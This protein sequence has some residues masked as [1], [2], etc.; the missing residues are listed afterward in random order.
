MLSFPFKAPKGQF[1]NKKNLAQSNCQIQ[2][3]LFDKQI[4][5]HQE[6]G[7]I[8]L[9]EENRFLGS[10]TIPLQALLT[11]AGKMDFNFKVNRPL[12]LPAYRVLDD[13]LF[14][15]DFGGLDDQYMR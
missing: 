11:N 13:E 4:F 15:A 2:V 1:F 5:R 3:S 7:K 12:A 6:E 9:Q 10:F 8:I 14:A